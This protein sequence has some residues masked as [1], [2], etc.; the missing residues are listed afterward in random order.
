MTTNA[1]PDE[2][3]GPQLLAQFLQ[4]WTRLWREEVHAQEREGKGEAGALA[5]MAAFPEM[6]AAPDI[7]TALE[8]WRTTMITWA[9]TLGGAPPSTVRSHDRETAPGPAAAAAAPDAR[10]VEI[11]RLTRRVDALEARLAKLE[12]P[13]RRRG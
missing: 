12:T 4:D 9:Q 3:H 8:L 13:R 10:D 11:E 7:S 5:G 1:N 6:P 2:P